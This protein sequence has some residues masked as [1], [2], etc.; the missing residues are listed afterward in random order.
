M[1]LYRKEKKGSL[2]I[3][4]QNRGVPRC[5]IF[6]ISGKPLAALCNPVIYLTLLIINCAGGA[7]MAG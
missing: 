5:C 4:L 7:G 2:Y 1:F 6:K 3:F